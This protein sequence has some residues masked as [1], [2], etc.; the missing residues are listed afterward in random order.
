MQN[1]LSRSHVGLVFNGT[2]TRGDRLGENK[3]DDVY[4]EGKPLNYLYS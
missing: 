4:C 3:N 2:V 1:A